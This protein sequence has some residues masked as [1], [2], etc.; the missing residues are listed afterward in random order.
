MKKLILSMLLGC[1]AGCIHHQR[2]QP[3]PQEIII[4]DTYEYQSIGDAR[5]IIVAR[6]YA[7]YEAAKQELGCSTAICVESNRGLLFAYDVQLFKR[8]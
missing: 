1:S 6:D 4:R 8:K 3:P 5:W 2:L 7:A